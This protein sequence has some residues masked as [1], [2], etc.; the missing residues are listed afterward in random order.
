MTLQKRAQVYYTEFMIT[1]FIFIIVIAIF[2]NS[3]LNTRQ[4]EGYDD[5]LI[6]AQ[7][8]S[9][10]LMSEGAPSNWTESNAEKIGITNGNGRIENSKLMKF[11][12]MSYED[13]KLVFNTYSDY[14]MF[15]EY[16]NGTRVDINGEQGIGQY[17]GDNSKLA[18]VVRFVTYDSDIVRM[19]IYVWQQ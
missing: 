2:A 4:S 5:F 19:V 6:Q 13:T 14:Y 16:K 8:I 17:D 12:N 11:A 3:V 10:Q 9:N 18:K 1:V 7:S 15:I